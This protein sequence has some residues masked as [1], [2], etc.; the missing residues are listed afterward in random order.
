VDEA[1][2]DPRRTTRAGYRYVADAH[3]S[4]MVGDEILVDTTAYGVAGE[5]WCPLEYGSPGTAS[6]YPF[7]ATVPGRGTGQ[8]RASEILAWRRPLD[9]HE[10]WRTILAET[11]ERELLAGVLP[12]WEDPHVIQWIKDGEVIP[13]LFLGEKWLRE[14]LGDEH[15]ERLTATKGEA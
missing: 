3:D 11:P 7:K 15:Y 13:P 5:H 1:T 12:A 8:W 14:H 2:I 4:I 10:L 9:R 6:V